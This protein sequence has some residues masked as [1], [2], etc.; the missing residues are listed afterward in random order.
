M[1]SILFL[2]WSIGTLLAGFLMFRQ[3]NY[4]EADNDE[5]HRYSVS[6]IIPARNEEDNLPILL[7]NINK[8]R[9][10]DI[11]VI[12]ADDGSIDESANV[13]RQYH[14][15]IVDV[16]ATDVPGK[17]FACYTGS[18]HASHDIL[19]FMDADT[20]FTE[21]YALAKVCNQYH[22]HGER[23]ILSVQPFH[24][25]EYRPERLSTIFNMMTVI[26]INIFSVFRKKQTAGTIFG[27][28]MLTNR[29][30]YE[31][32]GGHLSSKGYVIEGAGLYESYTAHHL[33]IHHYLGKGVVHFRMYSEGITSIIDGWKKHISSGAEHT[34]ISVMLLIMVWLSSSFLLPLFFVYIAIFD[35]TLIF[36]PIILYILNSIQ[37]YYVCKPVINI[38]KIEAIF[39]PFYKYFFFYVYALS[40][41]QIK[42]RKKISWK[43]REIDY[44]K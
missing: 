19:V 42:V 26:G 24:Q 9:N 33:P 7:S 8:Q 1:W 17:Y 36:I 31:T 32:A 43:D 3:K 40:V 38:N 25:T 6:I 21:D 23:G 29:V 35:L 37:F 44:D 27:P 18:R 41:Y 14:A 15:T 4:I 10:T 12:V 16:P 30:D 13:A 22:L 34:S 2:M 20:F 5:R 39:F 28:F 11:E